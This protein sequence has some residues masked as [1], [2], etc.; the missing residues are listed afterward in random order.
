MLCDFCQQ[1]K[2]RE[3]AQEIP[4]VRGRSFGA[5]HPHLLMPKKGFI[6]L[7]QKARR[8][9]ALGATTRCCHIP[10]LGYESFHCP[11]SGRNF[12]YLPEPRAG[13]SDL[14]ATF[15]KIPQNVFL[16]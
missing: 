12:S 10:V 4:P 7:Y 14:L 9:A 15:F 8:V 16:S 11:L 2:E 1:K 3:M 13:W 6:S 5:L